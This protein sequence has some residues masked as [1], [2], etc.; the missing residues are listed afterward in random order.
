MNTIIHFHKIANAE[1]VHLN[2]IPRVDTD[3]FQEALRYAITQNRARAIA[4]FA[5]PEER[6]IAPELNSIALLAVLVGA[7]GGLAILR[8]KPLTSPILKSM[9]NECPQ[10]H[11]F[12]RE[13]A[14]Q[15]GIIFEGHP[16]MKPVRYQ[17]P[18]IY[19]KGFQDPFQRSPSLPFTPNESNFYHIA[20][21][22]TNIFTLGPI[23]YRADQPGHIRFQ[24]HG[25]RIFFA[26][27]ALGY[28]HR[29]IEH[30]L[31][32]G[33]FPNTLALINTIDGSG[34]VAHTLSA[35]QVH[36]ALADIKPAARGN[37][38][39]AILLELERILTHVR[40][41][42]RTTAAVGYPTVENILLDSEQQIIHILGLISGNHLTHNIIYPG[43]VSSDI[44]E[45]FIGASGV[46][47]S[48]VM[49][50][51]DDALHILF[52]TPSFVRKLHC[53]K[54]SKE[55]C[56]QWGLN[57]L[58]CRA[59]G[60][61]FDSRSLFPS[62]HY[63]HVPIAALI[64]SEGDVYA[65]LLL[66][67]REI[68]VSISYIIDTLISLPEDTPSSFEG[69]CLPFQLSLKPNHVA[70]A[71][72]EGAFGALVHV[73]I[74]DAVGHFLQYKVID[75]TFRNLIALPH[76]LKNEFLYNFEI[77]NA[78]FNFSFHGHDL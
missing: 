35:I 46:L 68:Q 37:A 1:S 31:V 3:V 58:I 40:S 29:G 66:R 32:G 12:E 55:F 43:G 13:I 76:S 42:A 22:E 21:E 44:S 53:G 16:W 78:S 19:W 71:L 56:H 27:T 69:D 5:Y 75:P 47:I 77:I 8:T 30:A 62:G 17:A 67:W 33:P 34:S 11:Y 64:E 9:A 52:D 10:L 4:Y 23:R 38:I 14:E 65:R 15:W 6:P 74:T 48:K 39:R 20:G 54:I 61:N 25:E 57:G 59:T 24:C 70:V 41:I 2:N 18:Y 36:E 49:N 28:A 72:N 73:A 26:E 60:L 63:E 7:E 50:D 45:S 51:V